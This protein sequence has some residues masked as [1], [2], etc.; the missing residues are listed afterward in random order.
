[1]CGFTKQDNYF[2]H[3]VILFHGLDGHHGADVT[4]EDNNMIYYLT[5]VTESMLSL[6]EINS[7]DGFNTRVPDLRYV[8]CSTRIGVIGASPQ[9]PFNLSKPLFAMIV[10]FINTDI[11]TMK[12][13][14]FLTLTLVQIPQ[15]TDQIGLST[16]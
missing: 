1:M 14:H 3:D 9:I 13:L 5:D 2:L 16:P 10:H 11:I 4:G 8:A 7:S 12:M 15:I 6:L